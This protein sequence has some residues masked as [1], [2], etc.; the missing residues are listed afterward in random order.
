RDATVTGVQTCALPISRL[1]A[2]LTHLLIVTS[3]FAELRI[4]ATSIALALRRVLPDSVLRDAVSLGEVAQRRITPDLLA[5][6]RVLEDF[7]IV[8]A[9]FRERVYI[10]L[11]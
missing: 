2:T 6:T 8:R 1:R 9:S 4:L 11:F 5:R 7:D 3:L 10:G